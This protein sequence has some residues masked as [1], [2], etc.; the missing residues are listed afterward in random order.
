M[1][2]ISCERLKILAE[3]GRDL[4]YLLDRGYN[5]SSSL[6]LI[7]DKYRLAKAERSILYRSVYSS[8]HAERIA[9]K[10]LTAKD[11]RDEHILIDGFNVMNTIEAVLRGE[12][13]ILC[14]DGV[15]RDFSEVH[16]KYKLTEKTHESLKLLLKALKELR[17]ASVKILFESQISKSGEIAG[18]VRRLLREMGLVGDAETTKTVDSQ[19]QK[20]KQT[21]ITSDSAVLLRCAKFYDL[22]AYL[23]RWISRVKIISLSENILKTNKV[24]I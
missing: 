9:S 17:I 14:D 8:E 1:S 4:R 23:L 3:A 6:K 24:K 18:Y 19:L 7:G 5:R 13:L 10:R 12:P 2:T 20:S 15:L 22:P 11:L 16:G 21:I